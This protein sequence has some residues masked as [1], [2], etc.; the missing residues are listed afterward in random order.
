MESVENTKENGIIDY[1][2]RQQNIFDIDSLPEQA[3]H[4]ATNKNKKYTPLFNEIV[5]RYGLD[6]DG[7]W[8][9]ERMKHRGKH[10]HRYHDYILF[11]I[12]KCDMT[13]GGDADIFIREF[14]QVKKK[15]MDN[16]VMLRKAFW[17][18]KDYE[19]LFDDV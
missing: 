14:E 6:L 17:K 12:K 1:N 4:F 2:N 19:I 7:D 15:I 10:P 8:N 3:H 11:K 18:G 13:A 16:P 9:M 5:S